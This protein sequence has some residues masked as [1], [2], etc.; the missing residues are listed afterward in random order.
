MLNEILLL[1]RLSTR[2]FFGINVFLHTN[3]KKA[4]RRYRL[5]S[6]VMVF[7]VFLVIS[8]VLGLSY[9]LIFMGL[10]EILLQYLIAVSSVVIL[11]FGLFKAGSEMYSQKGIDIIYSLPVRRSS[12]LISRFLKL[13]TEDLI[14]T[15]L[16]M[17]PGCIMYAAFARPG[18]V[19]YLMLL[20][21]TLALPIIPLSVSIL[22]G[23]AVYA[24]SSRMK[25]RSLAEALISVV[26]V[27]AVLALSMNVGKLEEL[28]PEYLTELLSA[29]GDKI[30]SL[31]PPS[32]WAC[33]SYFGDISCILAYFGVS[34]GIVA[35]TFVFS[36]IVKIRVSVNSSAAYTE[37]SIKSSGLVSSLV[38]REF[39]RYFA[40]SV[41]V[42]NTIIGPIMGLLLSGAVLVVG[43]DKIHES[44]PLPIDVAS[45]IP[46]AFSAV[47]STMNTTSVSVS[48][49]GKNMWILKSLPISMKTVAEAKILMN[50]L[51]NLPFYLLSEILLIIALKP[52]PMQLLSVILIPAS[53]IVISTVFGL[54]V[55]LKMHSFDWESETYVVK[56]SATAAIGG[57][58]GLLLSLVMASPCFMFS[59]DL[60]GAV[61]LTVSSIAAVAAY[62][63][64]R[65]FEKINIE[66]L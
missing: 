21:V 35:L 53:V 37:E 44:M 45:L 22:F 39:R 17:I 20:P 2:N 16:V 28:T 15:F 42:T 4:K 27:V 51:L 66:S 31:Y 41:Y 30:E 13:Y 14:M 11:F 1:Y 58:F 47:F 36:S 52:S 8:Y 61:N 6:A 62:L 55:N 38:K 12:L 5:L 34:F 19:F 64:Y 3:D 23:T 49:E 50:L 26:I 7:L 54:F 10:S 46:F 25:R 65:S 48:M 43:V 57:F 18:A 56:Q 60:L 29:L 9:G 59:G 63:L 24:I 33:G 32:E 40:S